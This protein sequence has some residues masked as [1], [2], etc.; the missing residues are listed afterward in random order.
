MDD[1]GSVGLAITQSL[2][3]LGPVQFLMKQWGELD[4][5][6]TSVQRVVEFEKMPIE[7]SV[8]VTPFKTWP[9]EGRISFQSVSMQYAPNSSFALNDVSFDIDCRRKIGII[10]RTGS[11]KTSLISALFRLYDYYGTITI[12]GIDIKTISLKELRS[13]IAC[14][15]QEPVL[16][17]GTIRKNLDPFDEF[18]DFEIWEALG[19]VGLRKTIPNLNS[20]VLEEGMNFSVGQRQLLCLVRAILKNSKIVVLDE[21]TANVDLK[22]DEL[23]QN[24]I[25][26]KF[27]HCTVL[28]IAHRLNT[29]MDCDKIL[30][31]DNGSVAEFGETRDVLKNLG[32]ILNEND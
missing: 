4:A 15:P 9:D 11:G 18:N 20:L 23:I 1:L 10:G 27:K 32:T 31:I 19:E 7:E 22:T 13:K 30:V 3:L 21:A 2:L 6:M 28:T 25:R 17:P 29:V 16:F 12:D 5:Q 14:I 24:T 8:E 26:R